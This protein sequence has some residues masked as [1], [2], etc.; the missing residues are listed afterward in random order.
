MNMGLM[1]EMDDN[2]MINGYSKDP[3]RRNRKGPMGISL[4]LLTPAR[5]NE[6]VEDLK[7]VCGPAGRAEIE[8]E[9]ISKLK[10]TWITI[11]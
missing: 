9:Y 10:R 3:G 6:K 5:L 8:P 4:G 11:R 2:M 1:V 7:C